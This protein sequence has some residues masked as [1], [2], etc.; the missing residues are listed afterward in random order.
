MTRSLVGRLTLL[1]GLGL[2]AVGCA[3][4]AAL[5]RGRDAEQRRDYDVAVVEYTRA[6]RLHPNDTNTRLALER[7][8][9]R[10]SQEHFN[11]ARRLAALTKLDE[12][13]IEYELAAEM[14]PTNAEVEEEL[15]T[16]R[17]RLRSRVAVAREGKTELETLIARARDL[18]PPGLDLPQGVKMPSSLT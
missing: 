6:L 17:N 12:A 2:V 18:A 5:R 14:N 8:K 16:T 4:S 3:S 7:A 11:R 13:L 15:R 9:L 1:A 10:A